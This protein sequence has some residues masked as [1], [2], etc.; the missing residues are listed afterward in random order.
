MIK[1]LDLQLS[2]RANPG[3]DLAYF[4]GSSTSPAFREKH[5]DDLLTFYHSILKERLVAF[6]YP[7]NTYTL[8]NVKKDFKYCFPFG[9][10]MAR[11]H[12]MV[13]IPLHLLS[14]EC[15]QVVPELPQCNQISMY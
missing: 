2:R 15:G 14:I 10:C 13:S 12:I 7:D 5:L 8:E 3:V 11:I 9:F 4:L 6:G 1:I